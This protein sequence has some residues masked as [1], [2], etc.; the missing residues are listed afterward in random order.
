LAKSIAQTL[1]SSESLLGLKI[2]QQ[3]M[4]IYWNIDHISNNL[5]LVPIWY[6][7]NRH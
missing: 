5:P 7:T 6:Y 2:T 3:S 1:T 4:N